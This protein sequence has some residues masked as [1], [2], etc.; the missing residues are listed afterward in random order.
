MRT[1][2]RTTRRAG[3]SWFVKAAAGLAICALAVGVPA[4]AGS[5]CPPTGPND[6]GSD[7]ETIGTLPMVDDGSIGIDIVRQWYDPRPAI[8]VEGSIDDIANSLIGVEG[9]GVATLQMFGDDH[10][11]LTF[12][13]NV[14]AYFDRLAYRDATT[15]SIGLSV[16]T[17]VVGETSLYWGD[18]SRSLGSLSAGQV[19]LPLAMMEANGAL[20]ANA[21]SAVTRYEY[22]TRLVHRFETTPDMLILSQAH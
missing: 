15:I 3:R 13:G 17:P 1:N 10:I 2:D 12:Y 16:Q 14:Q 22:G 5:I 21:L 11:R 18:R 4:R 6:E 20:D 9:R 8:Y 19:G 7:D